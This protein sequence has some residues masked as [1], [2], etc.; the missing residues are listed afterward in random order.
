VRWLDKAVKVVLKDGSRIIIDDVA[1]VDTDI[2]YSLYHIV[3]TNRK[4][5]IVDRE[6]IYF[7][8]IGSEVELIF[9]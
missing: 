6:D 9:N 3:C 7:I 4:Q 2:Y 5:V 1:K 8:D